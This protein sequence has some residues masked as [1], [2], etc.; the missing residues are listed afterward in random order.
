MSAKQRVTIN[1]TEVEHKELVALAETNEVSASWLGRQAI[2]N[3]LEQYRQR[4]L[5]FPLNI[6]C[7]KTPIRN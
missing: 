5:Q 3:Y 7:S 4:E 6:K 2:K 1:L